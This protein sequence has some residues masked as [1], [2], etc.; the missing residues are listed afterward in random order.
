MINENEMPLTSRD[1]SEGLRKI[2]VEEGML[3]LVHSSMKAFG[4]WVV[5]GPE[6]V[7]LALEEA[8]GDSGTIVMPA[9]SSDLSEPSYWMRPPVPESWWPLIRAEMPAYRPD[10]TATRGMGAVVECFRRQE[11][12]L[13][14][15]HPQV[16][17]AARGPLAQTILEPH[18]LSP[19]LGEGSPLER[20][21]EL[22]GRALLLGVDHERNTTLHLAEH[23]AS[24]PN[25]E[26]LS[27]GSPMLR[28][29][30]REWVVFEDLAYRDDD[31][32]AVGEAFERDCPLAARGRI[33][34]ALVRLLPQRELI[35]YAAAWMEANRY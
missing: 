8:V 22:G 29:G 26:M 31:F 13:R 32:N 35:D 14:S 27:Q 4:R 24:Y 33:G 19:A 2:G 5:G 18:L 3:L 15:A 28:N 25:K 7:V 17:F 30:V 16:S 10:L 1:I 20:M 12:T 9:Q 34:D 11:G 6:A 23:R 21:A